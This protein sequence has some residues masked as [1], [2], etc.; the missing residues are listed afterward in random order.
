VKS[1]WTEFL[2]DVLTKAQSAAQRALELDPSAANARRL[3]GM[4][5]LLRGQYEL[6][7][8]ELDRAIEINP[9]D[10]ESHSG[11]GGV[12][13]WSGRSDE[14]IGAMQTAY[15]LDLNL[16]TPGAS[17]NFGLAYYLQA[18]FEDA[19]QVLER[20]LLSEH[21]PLY[22]AYS[23]AGLAA[24]YAQLGRAEEAARALEA[25]RTLQPFFGM[26]RFLDQ[27]KAGADRTL[28]DDGLRKAGLY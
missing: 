6:A 18:R 10:A 11:R 21:N 22:R 13:M 26:N 27:F 25:L 12:L 15:R 14:A 24:A 20:G 5:Y 9:S 4:L 8:A 1:G 23:Y 17:M 28:L 7:I 16:V 2:D 19:V 3:L